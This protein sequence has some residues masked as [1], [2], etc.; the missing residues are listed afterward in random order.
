MRSI[1][2]LWIVLLV[3]TN[4][5]T[6]T[7]YLKHAQFESAV[8]KSV[9][10]L[11]KKPTKTKEINVLREAFAKANQ[12]DMERINFLRT[13]GEPDVWDNIFSRYNALKNRQQQVKTLP[14][15]VLNAI[16]FVPVNYDE[17][18]ITAKRKAAEYFYAHAAQL[19][20]K[21]NKQNARLA[22][23]E[24]LKV[25]QYYS[26]YRDT[27][28]KL[29]E[30]LLIGRSNILF[31]IQNQSNIL[32][33][34]N[35]EQELL[36]ISMQDMNTLWMNYDTKPVDQL[37]YDYSIQ[38]NLKEIAVSPEQ[39]REESYVDQKEI[40][41][42]FKYKLDAK[43]NVMK[44]SAGNDIKI[45]IIKI[46]TCKMVITK[47]HKSAIIKGTLDYV[48]N[49][50]GQLIKTDPLIAETFFE[51]DAA[52]PYGDLNALSSASRNLLNTGHFIPF[53]S[54]PD[55]IMQAATR[56][57]DMTKSLIWNNKNIVNY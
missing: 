4:C 6:S 24:L 57:K 42:G 46:I 47:Q 32:V 45:P 50:T 49:H 36:K 53:P 26:D 20:E 3:F 31:K 13:S 23:N 37:D 8:Y 30:A 34:Q 41:D 10:K 38:L 48:N 52:T 40:T 16:N 44:D 17:E 55:M 54:N 12:A 39:V 28:A 56:L 1:F 29:Q 21:N 22:Y 11:R 35:F 15:N 5:R 7:H 18:V 19:L 33:P 43:G 25:K 9:S 51:N 2:V 27:D 14:T